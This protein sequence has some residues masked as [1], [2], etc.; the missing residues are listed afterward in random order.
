MI[1][2]VP[3]KPLFFDRVKDLLQESEQ[4]HM[5]TNNGPVKQKLEDVL[6]EKFNLGSDKRVAVTCNGTSALFILISLFEINAQKPLKWVTTAF[7]FPAATVNRLTTSVVD[8][9]SPDCATISLAN[10]DKYDGVIIPTLFGTIPPLLEDLENYCRSNN[11]ILILDN[12]SSPLS[13]FKDKNINEFGNAC[14]GSTHH[15]KFLGHN[16]GGFAV[17]PTDMYDSFCHL[18]NFGFSDDRNYNNYGS[19]AKMSDIS[20]AFTLS[21]IETYDS[22]EHIKV[23]NKYKKRIDKIEGVEIFNYSSQVVYGNMPII[24]SKAISHLIFHDVGI[25][26]NKYYKPLKSLPNSTE[27]FSKIVNF[28]LYSTLSDYEL[29]LILKKIEIEAAKQ[30]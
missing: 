30:Y 17:V 2:Y 20:A 13:K 19:N 29:N 11:K 14:I 3:F 26:A 28:P 7:N 10:I 8:I 23:Q 22:G 16:E 27:L 25:Q 15:T 9:I 12:A 5:F 18:T 21:H 4:T 1:K 24:F 6:H